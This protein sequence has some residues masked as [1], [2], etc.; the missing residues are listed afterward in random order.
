M[1]TNGHTSSSDI[2]TADLFYF[3]PPP[4][5]GRPR[6]YLTKPP[7]GV[8]SSNH[9]NVKRETQVEN[10]RGR[11]KDYTLD[12]TGFQYLL[13]EP[14][15]VKRF[16]D[17]AEV[18]KEYYP[19]SVEVLKRVTGASKVL[20]VDH[21]IRRRVE[22][23]TGTEDPK[24]RAPASIVHVDQT[25]KAAITRVHR[26]IESPE[27]A[28]RLLKKRYQIIN[29]WRPIG[30]PAL[31]MPLALCDFRS[32]N[33]K[34]DLVAVELI[35]PGYVG[36]T[37]GV[38]WNEGHKWKYLRGMGVD[39]A[40]LIKCYDSVQDGSVATLTPHTAFKD[41]STPEGTPPRESI[42]LRALV[43]YD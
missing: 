36:E 24:K 40:V 5:G 9:E 42:E 14:T 21:T 19:E 11:E 33:T 15:K 22:G 39:E 30:H 13:N 10:V 25:P 31:D 4:D 8:P 16:V 20:I 12:S 27:E 37:Y 35:F 23:E 3:T 41:P 2:V 18:Q 32:V 29:L 26:H 17:D 38:K 28:E 34:E 43:F 7:E 1:T 6:R